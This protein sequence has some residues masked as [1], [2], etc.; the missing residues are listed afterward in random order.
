MQN[1]STGDKIGFYSVIIALIAIFISVATPEIRIFTG[2]D[3]EENNIIN[4]PNKLSDED[5]AYVFIARAIQEGKMDQ[6]EINKFIDY[7]NSKSTVSIIDSL[8]FIDETIKGLI[9]RNDID[10]LYDKKIR[11]GFDSPEPLELECDGKVLYVN[12]CREY[13]E[14]PDNCGP[15]NG[16]MEKELHWYDVSCTILKA[17]KEGKKAKKSFL[18]DKILEE[19]PQSFISD[20]FFGEEKESERS[21]LTDKKKISGLNLKQVGNTIEYREGEDFICNLSELMRIDINGDGYEDALV[22]KWFW[23][24][25]SM[26][27]NELW[28]FSCKENYKFDVLN[29]Q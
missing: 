24:G 16:Y 6:N 8:Y 3:K 23:T 13:F 22:N 15:T 19:L 1:W 20:G 14:I 26:T 10:K 28:W 7:I 5:I 21:F 12:T 25:G 4:P 9:N 2:L 17:I 27:I 18:P 11:G 29:I